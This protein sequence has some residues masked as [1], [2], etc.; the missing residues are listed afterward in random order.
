MSSPATTATPAEDPRGRRRP[1]VAGSGPGRPSSEA[2]PSDSTA[3]Q[4]QRLKQLLDS[5]S[6]PSRSAEPKGL[7][8]SRAS[9]ESFAGRRASKDSV[10]G[11]RASKESVGGRTASRD[12]RASK[13]SDGLD[14][15]LGGLDAKLITADEI[16]AAAEAQAALH[17]T[18]MERQMAEADRIAIK[19]TAA[20]ITAASRKPVWDERRAHATGLAEAES[21]VRAVYDEA[22]LATTNA[23]SRIVKKKAEQVE[24]EHL[25]AAEKATKLRE[26]A[27][28]EAASAEREYLEAKVVG[29]TL[30]DELK[31]CEKVFEEAKLASEASH[32]K[33]KKA[34][35]IARK[36]Q[37]AIDA[38]AEAEATLSSS[39][40]GSPANAPG[41]AKEGK[42]T[43]ATKKGKSDFYSSLV[44][45]TE[46]MKMKDKAEAAKK[47]LY[48]AMLNAAER[49]NKEMPDRPQPLRSAEPEGAPP[50]SGRWQ[51]HVMVWHDRLFGHTASSKSKRNSIPYSGSPSSRGRSVSPIR[52]PMTSYPRQKKKKKIRGSGKKK[53]LKKKQ[54]ASPEKVRV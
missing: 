32:E 25:V 48:L 35:I 42:S 11:R 36:R 26:A 10:G 21:K 5:E 52:S 18:E 34:V 50:A 37:E 33:A 13:D 46:R 9:K 23:R 44:A 3:Q 20:Y 39:P 47:K 31:L 8:N 7:R 38:A 53:K 15:L 51:P 16:A 54:Q 19:M 6:Q 14:A 49:E 24:A 30:L 2:G 22:H 17:H 28:A 12:S 27:D 43:G 45:N 41:G 29:D 4:Q 40:D 1:S